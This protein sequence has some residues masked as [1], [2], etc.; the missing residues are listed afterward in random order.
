MFTKN[1]I[2]FLNS[3][4]LGR[5]ATVSSDGQPDVS[6]VGFEFDGQ[7]LYV[8]GHNLTATRKYKNVQAGRTKVALVVDSLISINP[9]HPLGIRIY[10][11]VD[12]VRR[13]GRLGE[14]LFLRITPTVSW[15]W[16]LETT[17]TPPDP[18]GIHKI[19]H[20]LPD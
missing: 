8:G 11:T 20:K 16:N 18:N 9:W 13:S 1:E 5:I 2:D 14:G 6:P 7:Y 3:Q 19:F 12:I 15:S 10:G 17:D 4:P